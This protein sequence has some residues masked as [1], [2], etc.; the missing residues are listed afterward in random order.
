MKLVED[1]GA[2]TLRSSLKKSGIGPRVVVY[3]NKVIGGHLDC[4]LFIYAVRQDGNGIREH[5]VSEYVILYANY[6]LSFPTNTE[7]MHYLSFM[8]LQKS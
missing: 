2:P 8:L 3:T 7:E 4:R 5:Q 6:S 1:M